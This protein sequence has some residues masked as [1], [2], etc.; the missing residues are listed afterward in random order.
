MPGLVNLLD[1]GLG[2]TE[3]SLMIL[4]TAAMTL[5]LC[6]QV[7]LRYFF[8]APLFWAEEVSVQLLIMISFMGVSYLVHTGKLVRVDILLLALKPAARIWLLRL[9]DLVGLICFGILAWYATD[10]ILRPEVKGEVS[11][12]TGIPLWYNYS[13][14]VASIYCMTIHQCV[15]VLI[16]ETQ[17]DHQP[18]P[19]E[20]Q[21]P[22]EE[23][24]A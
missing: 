8:N 7:I 6:A 5:I 9:L 14:L 3:R 24:S 13:V 18:H 15:K 4:L 12:T 16:P 1:R 20:T 23:R 19:A 10:W 2:W 17:D 11:P 21:T 22:S